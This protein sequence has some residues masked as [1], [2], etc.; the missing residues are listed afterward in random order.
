[1]NSEH[2]HEVKESQN[3]EQELKEKL[4]IRQEEVKE[5]TQKS[6]IE[7]RDIDCQFQKQFLK[8]DKFIEV[9]V[10]CPISNCECWIQRTEDAEK[11][12]DLMDDLK[13]SDLAPKADLIVGSMVAYKFYDMWHRAMILSVEP[14]TI[15]I[16][17]YGINCDVK[18]KN[19][20]RDLG[21]YKNVPSFAR[22]IFIQNRIDDEPLKENEHLFVKLVSENDETGVLMVVI[23]QV[24]KASSVK[25]GPSSQI[26][27]DSQ[28]N[29]KSVSKNE[30]SPTKQEE[31]ESRAQS[32]VKSP[33]SSSRGGKRQTPVIPKEPPCPTGCILDHLEADDKGLIEVH[34]ELGKSKFSITIIPHRF[35]KYYEKVLVLF[36]EYC[37]EASKTQSYT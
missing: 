30:P 35:S 33:A 6:R 7:K 31:D 25:N 24:E 13:A 37:T 19:D 8:K 20:I 9:E 3:L 22:K 27:R 29:H 1:M 14:L 16:I 23:P 4:K 17:D 28:S 2:V 15:N 21:M 36:G 12:S 26:R 18:N 5:E 10:M 11:F 34:T 32:S